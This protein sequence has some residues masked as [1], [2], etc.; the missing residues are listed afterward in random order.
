MDHKYHVD[1]TVG[2]EQVKV[3]SR[4]WRGNP[5]KSTI[6]IYERSGRQQYIFTADHL[7]RRDPTSGAYLFVNKT[8]GNRLV[9]R[10]MKISFD[11]DFALAQNMHA[12]TPTDFSFED[13]NSDDLYAGNDGG[14]Y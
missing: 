12:L 7:D 11:V 9:L 6:E 14:D 3:S 1:L 13:V 4:E 5:L 10:P 8:T 2:G